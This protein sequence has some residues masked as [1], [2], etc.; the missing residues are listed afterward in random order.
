VR[1]VPRGFLPKKPTGSR[2]ALYAS[3]AIRDASVAEYPLASIFR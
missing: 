2:T 3:V 1:E